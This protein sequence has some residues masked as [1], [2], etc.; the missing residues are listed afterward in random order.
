MENYQIL[1]WNILV[2][3]DDSNNFSLGIIALFFNAV[4]NDITLNWSIYVIF[5]QCENRTNVLFL[6][7]VDIKQNENNYFFGYETYFDISF[8]EGIVKFHLHY[9]LNKSNTWLYK[10]DCFVFCFVLDLLYLKIECWWRKKKGLPTLV[11]T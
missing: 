11:I 9:I 3:R 6:L 4:Y 5:V 2:W 1:K 8:I 10:P 7:K